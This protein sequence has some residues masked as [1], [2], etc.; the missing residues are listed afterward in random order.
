MGHGTPE[1][2]RSGSCA[3]EK[4]QRLRNA[5]E[6]ITAKIGRAGG[7]PTLTHPGSASGNGWKRTL[8]SKQWMRFRLNARNTKEER[9]RDLGVR[10]ASEITTA[11]MLDRYKR[12]QKARI[13]P[14]TY[15]R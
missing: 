7:F 11:A 10:P 1:S 15:E 14:T 5:M 13:R 4:C 9:A 6:C 2:D 12:H 8:G 3:E